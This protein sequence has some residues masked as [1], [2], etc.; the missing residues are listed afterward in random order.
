[1]IDIRVVVEEKFLIVH[2]LFKGIV[3]DVD[4]VNGG[5]VIVG[6]ELRDKKIGRTETFFIDYEARRGKHFYTYLRAGHI[7]LRNLIFG[8]SYVS[9]ERA[10]LLMILG[11]SFENFR[12][13]NRSV[14]RKNSVRTTF[15]RI[16]SVIEIGELRSSESKIGVEMPDNFVEIRHSRP[17]PRAGLR[18]HRNSHIFSVRKLTDLIH[19]GKSRV[20]YAAV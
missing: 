10:D 19:K 3:Y 5:F 17:R 14:D 2:C 4:V 12:V 1:M 6:P 8:K 13:K 20:V 11:K 9:V 18:I 7:G 15:R 16:H